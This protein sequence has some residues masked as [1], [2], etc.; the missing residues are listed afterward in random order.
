MPFPAT[1]AQLKEAGYRFIAVKI[2]PCGERMELWFTPDGATI[3]MN[4]MTDDESPAVSHWGTCE[5]AA[6]FRRKKDVPK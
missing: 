2:C 5:K 4:P 1:Q 6:Q 3:P